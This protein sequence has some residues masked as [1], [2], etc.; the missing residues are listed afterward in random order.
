MGT[1]PP[2]LAGRGKADALQL[3][4]ASQEPISQL[5]PCRRTNLP[6]Q[7]SRHV[8]AGSD[9][10]SSSRASHHLLRSQPPRADLGRLEYP[11]EAR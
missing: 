9:R 2:P 1:I 5:L 7:S 11:V 6:S 3:A 8:T 10:L 4:F